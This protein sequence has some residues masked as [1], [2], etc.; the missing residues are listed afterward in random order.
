MSLAPSERRALAGIEDALCNSDPRLAA[1]LARFSPLTS[2]SRIPQWK[3]WARWRL[4]IRDLLPTMVVLGACGLLVLLVALFSHPN[5]PADTPAPG[6]A[7]QR[8][9]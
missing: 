1:Q 8:P 6:V 9:G 4:W 5:R 2:R 3:C 7:S